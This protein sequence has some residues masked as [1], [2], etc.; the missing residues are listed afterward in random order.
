[1]GSAS[2]PPPPQN[3]PGKDLVKFTEGMQTALPKVYDLESQYRDKFGSL[4]LGDI[5]QLLLGGGGQQGLIG[6]GGQATQG[7][8]QQLEAARAADI[9]SATGQ[10]GS[11]RNL[12]GAISPGSASL[13]NSQTQMAQDAYGRAGGLSAQEARMA[14]QTAREAFGARGRLGDT[15]SVAGELL[16]REDVMA[17]KRSEAASLGQQAFGME[18]A[19][20]S[21]ALSLLTGTPASTL[22]GQDYLNQGRGAVGA[23]TP[24]LIDTGAGISLGQQNAANMAN[25]QSSVAAAKNAQSSANAQTGTAVASAALM[26]LAAF[27]DEDLKE[28]KKKVGKTKGGH[29]IYTYNYKGHAKTFMGPMA[30][31][32]EKKKPSAVHLLGGARTVDYAQL[33]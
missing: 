22:L 6:L 32:V 27:S 10:A 11:A 31:E 14:D 2:T 29:D 9:T 5:T 17:K 24:Q 19:F 30:Q 15:A 8:Q 21:P 20:S 4:N 3:N 7:A 1:M 12:L 25:W 23:N 18:Q 28:N 13:M 33:S 26:A 16:S